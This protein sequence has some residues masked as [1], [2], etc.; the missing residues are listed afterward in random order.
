MNEYDASINTKD[1]AFAWSDT[2]AINRTNNEDDK[3][4]KKTNNTN[5]MWCW[6]E[7]P[8]DSRALSHAC[9]CIIMKQK[10][11]HTDANDRNNNKKVENYWKLIEQWPD[12]TTNA[13]RCCHRTNNKGVWQE[14]Y[15]NNNMNKNAP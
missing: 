13:D 9:A 11:K 5:T 4:I 2:V 15:E 1:I 6:V 10:Y 8:Q 12:E 14:I 3:I 7:H